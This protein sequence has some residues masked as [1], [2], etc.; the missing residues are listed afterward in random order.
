M[1]AV[2]LK[3]EKNSLGHYIVRPEHVE[4]PRLTEPGTVLIKLAAA[5]L[6]HRDV[7]MTQGLYP[8]LQFDSVLGAD[9]AGTVVGAHSEADKA[10]WIGRRVLINSSYHWGPDHMRP[11]KDFKILGL[12]PLPGTLAE[13][14]VVPVGQI[15]EVPQHLDFIQAAA[16]PLAGITAYRAVFTKG[17]VE[18]GR[19]VLVTGI[20]GGV[21][22]FALQFALAAGAKVWVTSSSDDKIQRAIKLGA[23]GGANYTQDNWD[24]KLLKEAGPFDSIIDS[25]GGDNV[26]LYVKMLGMGGTLS[27]YGAT[28]GRDTSLILPLVFLKNVDIR[29]VSMGSDTDF[30]GMMK[31][32][33]DT[34]LVP[35]VDSVRPFS[36]TTDAF[37]EMRLGK[38]FG[39]LVIDISTKSSL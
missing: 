6:N 33:A 30:T 5:A 31:L 13:Y 1:K 36:K 15:A 11:S 27:F 10:R 23:T 2:L 38:Q 24:T 7:W 26:V 29:G 14:I 25:A 32:I 37:E 28:A 19:R 21:A 16:I 18:K 39:K 8:G 9:G 35:V 20:G 34:K 3:K 22:L 17:Q 4:T 12:K